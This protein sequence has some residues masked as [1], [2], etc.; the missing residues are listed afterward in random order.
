[1]R[2]VRFRISS[3]PRS[4]EN[5]TDKQKHE[6]VNYIHFLAGKP[7]VE[8]PPAGSVSHPLERYSEYLFSVYKWKCRCLLKPRR[9]IVPL[10][11]GIF[12]VGTF[13]FLLSL[14]DGLVLV[15][16]ESQNMANSRPKKQNEYWMDRELLVVEGEKSLCVTGVVCERRH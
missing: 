14:F 5:P 9:K 15:D 7:Q 10:Q 6:N 16:G 2:W 13:F 4:I 1:M 3:W 12:F 11:S 8:I